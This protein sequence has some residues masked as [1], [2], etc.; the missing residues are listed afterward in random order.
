MGLKRPDLIIY[1]C[2]CKMRD[3]L[4]CS[5]RFSLPYKRSFVEYFED[6]VVGICFCGL[7]I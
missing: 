3:S 2:T 5:E 4:S 1:S 7:R 6:C